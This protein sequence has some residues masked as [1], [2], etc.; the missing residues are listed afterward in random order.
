[1]EKIRKLNV[2]KKLWI[3]SIILFIANLFILISDYYRI[4]ITPNRF[5]DTLVTILN[6]FTILI[7][8]FAV[9]IFKDKK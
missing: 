7:H 5:S 4:R 1:M 9:I 3:I 2:L 8:I 6:L